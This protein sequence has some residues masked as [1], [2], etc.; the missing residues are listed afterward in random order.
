MPLMIG[1]VNLN[2]C[3]RNDRFAEQQKPGGRKYL[4]VRHRVSISNITG[5]EVEMKTS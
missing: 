3:Y 1:N 4:T 2:S 5:S